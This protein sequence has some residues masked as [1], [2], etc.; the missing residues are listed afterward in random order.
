[1]NLLE[2]GEKLNIYTR[3]GFPAARKISPP[4]APRLR[5]NRR[6]RGLRRALHL[7]P[8]PPTPRHGHRFW[9]A[10][11]S[12]PKCAPPNPSGVQHLDPATAEKLAQAAAARHWLC[13]GSCQQNSCHC[14]RGVTRR[15]FCWRRQAVREKLMPILN[16]IGK[17]PLTSRTVDAACAVKLISNLD[18][19]VQMLRLWRE[20]LRDGK[21]AGMDGNELL[22][23][24]L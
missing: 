3:R 24:L 5:Q 4:T 15:F 10:M 18:R 22:D 7:P 8:K 19:H 14:G 2:A 6:P 20:G 23:L 9:A 12:T 13:P 21:L 16:K 1:M 17:P 11:A